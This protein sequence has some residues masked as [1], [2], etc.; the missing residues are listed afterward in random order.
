M[1]RR[2]ALWLL[3]LALSLSIGLQWAVVQ[4]A[5]WVSMIVSYS[6]EATISE[7]LTMTFDGNHP[8]KLC[9][10][11]QR[12]ESTQKKQN[13][14]N[15][16]VKYVLAAPEM[17]PFVFPHDDSICEPESVCFSVWRSHGPPSPPPE[18][19]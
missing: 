7:S 13:T 5:A 2:F 12:G 3:V 1:M 9:E 8:C 16:P 15:P 19:V 17:E 10:A 6:Q 18:A 11:A 14:D 4:G